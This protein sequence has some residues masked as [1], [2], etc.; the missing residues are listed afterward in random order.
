VERRVLGFRDFGDL[1]YWI[2]LMVFRIFG[3]LVMIFLS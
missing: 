3:V 1:G 2:G